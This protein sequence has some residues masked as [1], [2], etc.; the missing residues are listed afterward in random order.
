MIVLM[1]TT[2]PLFG[3]W[4]E[5]RTQVF[6]DVVIPAGHKVESATCF[7][8]SIR[9]EGELQ[10]DAV[11][12]WGDIEVAG[13]VGGDV[14]AVAGGTRLATNSR[15]QGDAVSVFGD[16]ALASGSRI[17]GDVVA[18]LGNIHLSPGA[19]I[20]KTSSASAW[21]L[22]WRLP[23]RW[24]AVCTMWVIGLLTSI[25]LSYLCYFVLGKARLEREAEAIRSRRWRTALFGAIILA[26]FVTAIEVGGESR[27]DDWIE[28]PL[29]LLLLLLC[30]PGYT[31]MSLHLGGGDGRG[32]KSAILLGTV[33]LVTIQMTPI[34]GWLLAGV[35]MILSLG[36]LVALVPS[37]PRQR[38]VGGVSAQSAP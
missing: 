4:G 26:V 17:S 29:C 22:F 5:E 3:Q 36:S 8:C 16:V 32:A 2:V 30:A 27:F 15:V 23:A 37:R 10:G 18:S 24:R 35:L 25:P 14:V 11:A 33:A 13:A 20:G 19:S 38:T 12:E 7:F 9:V 6:S 34:L 28:W 31:A 21:P 1:T